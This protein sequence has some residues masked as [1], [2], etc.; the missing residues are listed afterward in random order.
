MP[1]INKLDNSAQEYFYSLP[2]MVQEQIVQCNV[3]FSCRE[4]IERYYKN[5]VC[6]SNNVVN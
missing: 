6:G 2:L 5:T 1:D 3:N 4:D